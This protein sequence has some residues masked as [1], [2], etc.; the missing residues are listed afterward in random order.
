M[1]G[2]YGSA[3]ALL[4]YAIRQLAGEPSYLAL[5]Q[6]PRER[7]FEPNAMTGLCWLIYPQDG[8]VWHNGG[9][10]C[11]KTFFG[12]CRRNNAAVAV[13]S[14]QKARGGVTPEEIGLEI[15]RGI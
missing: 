15:L 13:L 12:F 5:G 1:G 14:N 9:T 7:C 11:F 2:L 10:G 4:E 8:I 3:G 6:E